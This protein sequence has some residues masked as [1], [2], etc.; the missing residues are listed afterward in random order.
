M[1]D[2]FQFLFNVLAAASSSI[3]ALVGV[4]LWY[5]L[6]GYDQLHEDHERRLNNLERKIFT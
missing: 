2:Q 4:K 5:K 1:I 3:S 6:G